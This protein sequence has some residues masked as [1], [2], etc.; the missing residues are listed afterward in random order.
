MH[1]VRFNEE[2][3]KRANNETWLVF[4]ILS[5][6][7]ITK[8]KALKV[9]TLKQRTRRTKKNPLSQYNVQY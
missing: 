6:E 9:P 8:K 1:Y 5:K 4:A 3:D 7:R 2:K